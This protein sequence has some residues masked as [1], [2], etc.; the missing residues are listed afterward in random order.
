MQR[1]PKLSKPP[2]SQSDRRR[3]VSKQ[4]EFRGTKEQESQSSKK[5][6]QGYDH[7][8]RSLLPENSPSQIVV[9]HVPRNAAR[10]RRDIFQLLCDSLCRQVNGFPIIR[11]C[12]DTILRNPREAMRIAPVTQDLSS[13]DV[14]SLNVLR[15]T[16]ACLFD[17]NRGGTRND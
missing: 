11:R 10:R 15:V 3:Q 14:N 13:I 4:T 12:P 7:I 9:I 2:D 16:V 6:E 1:S 5:E 17:H 8:G